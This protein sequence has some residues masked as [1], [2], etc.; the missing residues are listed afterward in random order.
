MVVVWVDEHESLHAALAASA[1]LFPQVTVVRPLEDE[2][3]LISLLSSIFSL[4]V[5]FILQAQ[6]SLGLG[7]RNIHLK[8][9]ERQ[10]SARGEMRQFASGTRTSEFLQSWDY[11]G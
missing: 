8:Y 4:A 3:T 9:S 7:N 10:Y 2:L 1:D 5:V 6:Y 11:K